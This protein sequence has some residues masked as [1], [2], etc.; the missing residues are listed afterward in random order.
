MTTGNSTDMP[1]SM[2]MMEQFLY[3]TVRLETSGGSGEEAWT[4]SGTAFAY[5]H[6]VEGKGDAI[7]LVTNRHVV[8]DASEGRFFFRVSEDKDGNRLAEGRRHDVLVP[9]IR[10]RFTVHPDDDIDLAI[11]PIGPLLKKI[12]KEKAQPVFLRALPSTLIP[13]ETVISKLLPMEEVIFIGYP[14]GLYDTVNLLPIVRRGTT[15]TPLRYDY[16]GR[17]QFLIDASV[18]PGS[19]GSPVVICNE[20]M[21]STPGG[22]V[23]GKRSFLLGIMSEVLYTTEEGKLEFDSIPTGRAGLVRTRSYL[24]L[25]IAVKAGAIQELVSE[26][27]SKWS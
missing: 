6:A 5:L 22:M 13:S 27:M 23:A 7:F 24:D 25:G 18:F 4:G 12:A 3:S 10:D 16:E 19:S 20:G 14:E 2:G 1:P 17:P 21:Y 8:A 26:V 15:A 11:T 9:D